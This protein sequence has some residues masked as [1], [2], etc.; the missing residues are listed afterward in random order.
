M[1]YLS[2]FSGAN[3]GDLGAQH[4]LNWNCVGYVEWEN[5][6]AK[7][8]EQ[9]IKDRL[10]SDAPIFN[11][12]IQ[13]FNKYYAESYKGI[14]GITGGF[15]CQPFSVAGKQ[16]GKDDSRNMWPATLRT[17]EIISPKFAFLENVPGLLSVGYFRDILCGLSEIGYNAKWQVLSAADCSAPHQR[18]RIWILAYR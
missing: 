13:I 3:G 9:R 7:V 1:N 2:L 16:R 8:T 18:K 17:I 10:L 11:C 14:S 6:C 12:D 4:L 5:Y 15:P